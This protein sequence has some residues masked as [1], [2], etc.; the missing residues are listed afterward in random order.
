MDHYYGV[1]FLGL[2]ALNTIS[3]Y[4]KDLITYPAKH[5]ILCSTGKIK[6]YR[7]GTRITTTWEWIN[8]FWVNYA[9]KYTKRLNKFPKELVLLKRTSVC[10][11][12]LVLIRGQDSQEISFVQPFAFT[13]VTQ[14]LIREALYTLQSLPPTPSAGM[15]LTAYSFHWLSP[16]TKGHDKATVCGRS[17]HREWGSLYEHSSWERECPACF[18]DEQDC[19]FGR[20]LFHSEWTESLPRKSH[21][22]QRQQTSLDIPLTQ[23]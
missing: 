22:F 16:I 20:Q 3:L 2:Q 19:P 14:Q 6:S 18:T 10:E 21:A 23:S 9:L 17:C 15:M 11:N 1:D 8:D 13:L 12:S 5:L 7:F 4:G